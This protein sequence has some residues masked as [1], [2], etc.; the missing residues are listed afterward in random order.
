MMLS[1]KIIP[2]SVDDE[3]VGEPLSPTREARG[4][5]VRGDSIRARSL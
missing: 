1:Y 2:V 4:T 3:V 5:T